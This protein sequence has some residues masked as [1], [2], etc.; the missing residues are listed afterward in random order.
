M[1]T[2]LSSLLKR[3]SHDYPEIKLDS[4]AIYF[5]GSEDSPE[6]MDIVSTRF[7]VELNFD[8]LFQDAYENC[9]LNYTCNQQSLSKI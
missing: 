7:A 9:Q 5:S 8:L 1:Y 4:S 6:K 2:D 3:N